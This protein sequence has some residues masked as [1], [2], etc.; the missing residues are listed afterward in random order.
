MRYKALESAH[1]RRIQWHVGQTID[2]HDQTNIQKVR[3]SS[4]RAH[5]LSKEV[6]SISSTIQYFLGEL[7]GV[8]RQTTTANSR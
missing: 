3:N 4:K 5:A 2:L 7:D 1:I 6:G 8:G